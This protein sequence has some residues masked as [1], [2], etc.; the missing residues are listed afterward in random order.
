MDSIVSYGKFELEYRIIEILGTEEGTDV[1]LR[2]ISGAMPLDLGTIK[3][4]GTNNQKMILMD[5]IE[6]SAHLR[7]ECEKRAL[8]TYRQGRQERPE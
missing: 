8:E 2:R 1:W 4:I 7:N 5:R 3:S 6:W